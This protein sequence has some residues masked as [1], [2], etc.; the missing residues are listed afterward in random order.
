LTT[1]L[2]VVLKYADHEAVVSVFVGP[3]KESGKDLPEEKRFKVDQIS[4]KTGSF[5]D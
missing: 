2:L 4:I 3:S 1:T 5:F